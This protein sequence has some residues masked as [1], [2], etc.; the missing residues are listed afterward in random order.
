MKNSTATHY[1]AQLAGI[2]LIQLPSTINWLLGQPHKYAYI[3]SSHSLSFLTNVLINLFYVHLYGYLFAKKTSMK[4]LASI[5]FVLI[6]IAPSFFYQVSMTLK[7]LLIDLEYYG[8]GF[9]VVKKITPGYMA[10]NALYIAIYF[11]SH[12]WLEYKDQK[13]KALKAAALANEAQLEMLQY[14]IN[15]HFLFNS[16]NTIQSLVEVD[17]E[18]AKETIADLS[19]FFRHTLSG[20]NQVFIPLKEELDAL[21]KYLSIQKERFKERL[22]INYE[23]DPGSLSTKIPAFIRWLKIPLNTGFLLI[24]IYWNY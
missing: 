5:S 20:K 3:L 19:D 23:I 22:I 18:R 15:P 12:Y 6:L 24:M 11:F 21:K 16:L 17:K 4:T 2:I 13:E 1:L 10:N 8:L 14:Q 9:D 7:W